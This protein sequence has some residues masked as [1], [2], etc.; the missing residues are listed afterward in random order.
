MYRM[1]ET[2]ATVLP[3]RRQKDLAVS[4][5]LDYL[6]APEEE[7]VAPILED[8]PSSRGVQYPV[9]N[10]DEAKEGGQ[11]SRAVASLTVSQAIKVS[12]FCAAAGESVSFPV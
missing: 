2:A 4:R 11:Y 8:R 10:R 5:F 3:H 12:Y 7:V 1:E 6:P 9:T